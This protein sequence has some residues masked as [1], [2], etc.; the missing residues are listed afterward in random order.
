VARIP[1]PLARRIDRLARRAHR[2]HRYAHHPLCAQY[3]GELVSIGRRGRVC[4]G[5]AFGLLGAT[6]GVVLG[7]SIPP[8]FLLAARPQLSVGVCGVALLSGCALLG[9]LRMPASPAP[10]G[11]RMSKLIT[12]FGPASALA[13]VFVLGVRIGGLAGFGGAAA[14]LTAV[15][16]A[17]LLYRH[18]GPDRSAC[19]R[20]PERSA[21]IVCSGFAPIVRRERAFARVARRMLA[22]APERA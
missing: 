16:S 10:V 4:R 1:R 18:R 15:V 7:G 12:R 22:A 11:P 20:C 14:C 17:W 8:S 9:S 6:I 2:F 5:C 13:G 19:P 21:V 3:Q